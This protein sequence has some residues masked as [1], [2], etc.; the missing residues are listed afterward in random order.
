M[1]VVLII[2]AVL[3]TALAAV[4]LY[5]LMAAWPW[6]VFTALFIAIIWIWVEFDEARIQKEVYGDKDNDV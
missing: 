6:V 4:A 3:V 1:V 2:I 5:F